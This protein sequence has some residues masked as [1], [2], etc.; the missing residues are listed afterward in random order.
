[1]L[2]NEYC[3]EAKSP[4]ATCHGRGTDVT[5]SCPQCEGTG[6]DPNEENPFA[7]CHECYGEGEVHLDTCPHCSGAESQDDQFL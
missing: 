5:V 4:C 6:F 3:I 2:T 7:Q 1:M